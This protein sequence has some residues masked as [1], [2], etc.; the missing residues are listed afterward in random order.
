MSVKITGFAFGVGSE[1]WLFHPEHSDDA[2]QRRP[3][4]LTAVERSCSC[5]LLV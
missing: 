2:D 3:E 4:A 1:W 5:P